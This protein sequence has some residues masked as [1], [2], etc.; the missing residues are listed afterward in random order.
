MLNQMLYRNKRE[1]GLFVLD[2]CGYSLDKA[3][4]HKDV[5]S[6]HLHLA[7]RRQ[8]IIDSER[9]TRLSSKPFSWEEGGDETELAEVLAFAQA[10]V[11]EVQAAQ[12]D[13]LAVRLLKTGYLSQLDKA[14]RS[15][16]QAIRFLAHDEPGFSADHSISELPPGDKYRQL[17]RAHL[18][19]LDSLLLL[20]FVLE[21]LCIRIA[22]N[23]GINYLPQ[24]NAQVLVTV[25]N[26]LNRWT[27]NN[28]DLEIAALKL[29][30]RIA[31]PALPL[32]NEM[33]EV[34]LNEAIPFMD[35]FIRT[36][37]E[38]REEKNKVFSPHNLIEAE[39]C[40][41][42]LAS[43]GVHFESLETIV[44][45][46]LL[47]PMQQ[48]A[49][50]VSD[51]EG[52]VIA[53]N[54]LV[55]TS[56]LID[57]SAQ[58][59][60][61]FG[62]FDR[63]ASLPGKIGDEFLP[64]WLIEANDYYQGFRQTTNYFQDQLDKATSTAFNGLGQFFSRLLSF[65]PESMRRYFRYPDN[66]TLLLKSLDEEKIMQ[67]VPSEYDF[68][69][70]ACANDPSA[71]LIALTFYEL[72][73]K[74]GIDAAMQAKLFDPFFR[75]VSNEST[76][77]MV[78]SEY[79]YWSQG[80]PYLQHK[81]LCQQITQ[82]GQHGRINS[83][84]Q[85][86]LLI[87]HPIK[88]E[89][90]IALRQ[91]QD[92][93]LTLYNQGFNIE[94]FEMLEQALGLCKKQFSNE[95][96]SLFST[97]YLEP[98]VARILNHFLKISM[99]PFLEDKIDRQ[100]M[101]HDTSILA[102]LDKLPL[103]YTKIKQG[104]G[105]NLDELN[106]LSSCAKEESFVVLDWSKHLT[107]YLS[108]PKAAPALPVLLPTPHQQLVLKLKA[109]FPSLEQCLRVILE[110]L[111]RQ[112]NSCRTLNVL[113]N[114]SSLKSLCESKLLYLEQLQ[115]AIN[116][117]NLE[118]RTRPDT[119]AATLS[120][121]IFGG[122]WDRLEHQIENATI[123]SISKQLIRFSWN[124]LLNNSF[125]IDNQFIANLIHYSFKNTPLPQL[126][127]A[128]NQ[129]NAQ[130]NHISV[131]ELM[132]L[133]ND[134]LA[135]SNL[136]PR[137]EELMDQM[138]EQLIGFNSANDNALNW[139]TQFIASQAHRL[140]GSVSRETLA[141]LLP[142]S[143]LATAAF[144]VLQSDT[145]R[146]T[147]SNL[148]F[149]LTQSY[150]DSFRFKAEEMLASIK[151]HLYPLLGIEIQK[152]IELR[153][154]NYAVNRTSDEDEDSHIFAMYYLQYR[155]ILQ[156]NPQAL[157]QAILALIFSTLSE[158][159]LQ[160]LVVVFDDLDQTMGYVPASISA[161]STE[162]ESQLD[163]LMRTLNFSDPS[164]QS[165]L[166]LI[167]L[168][169]LLVMSLNTALQLNAEQS[170]LRQEEVIRVLARLFE[171]FNQPIVPPNSY[172]LI[173]ES[174]QK[175][176]DLH[177]NRLRQQVETWRDELSNTM[178]LKSSRLLANKE[179]PQLNRSVAAVNRDL[180]KNNWPRLIF[181]I[182]IGLYES[183]S[184][185]SF[186]A[187]IVTPVVIAATGASVLQAI[188]SILGITAAVG[189]S[190]TVVGAVTL[191]L[192]FM[193][194]FGVKLGQ[195]IKRQ[196][197]NFKDAANNPSYSLGK[198]IG[199]VI[200]T[201]FKCLGWALFRSAFTD[202]LYGKLMRFFPSRAVALIQEE[203]RVYPSVEQVEEEA[204]AL[205]ELGRVLNEFN[206]NMTAD[207][208][209][210]VKIAI[211]AAIS[212]YEKA[213]PNDMRQ[214]NNELLDEI[215][216]CR[217][218]L[219]EINNMSTL[220]TNL[221]LPMQQEK[222]VDQV[223]QLEYSISQDDAKQEGFLHKA[224]IIDQ[225]LLQAYLEEQKNAEIALSQ[226]ESSQPMLIS[227]FYKALAYAGRFFTWRWFQPSVL[228]QTTSIIP[229]SSSIEHSTS[230]IMQRLSVRIGDS[231]N[232]GDSIVLTAD[233]INEAVQ[234]FI[235]LDLEEM[236]P[237]VMVLSS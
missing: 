225:R 217:H 168:N 185:I 220:I 128:Y 100:G 125:G 181:K 208:L 45:K 153:A 1:L 124:V 198:K 8:T 224:I 136:V 230:T 143:F 133:L 140:I 223:L 175:L 229:S 117:I 28:H 194:R 210:K 67:S 31:M 216:R 134:P 108:W 40:G 48:C 25:L 101:G 20:P 232:T 212:A 234:E 24:K 15:S 203:L 118:I 62:H 44:E 33:L 189:T 222:Y 50:A 75:E 51:L 3:G 174:R 127:D 164:N 16:E 54:Q 49:A 150:H 116:V 195:E 41:R 196:L 130:L 39:A 99:L 83:P 206:E 235:V 91:L 227:G 184:F 37:R 9:W 221:A 149:N 182:L 34:I 159:Q 113:L 11:A 61:L 154:L 68:S 102:V 205:T 209:D 160:H 4:Y 155:A 43:L 114:Q 94:L 204:N 58:I 14:H 109:L 35:R 52:I 201:I 163:F 119:L 190:A 167:L 180:L 202:F 38:F 63:L 218:M 27:N 93:E 22:S 137:G 79:Q 105:L 26:N 80:F 152:S 146:Q 226:N 138:V 81:D 95:F 98:A 77:V 211:H 219:V 65:V 139:A 57:G 172:D 60:R 213:L 30:L 73:E 122:A 42:L 96:P 69:S 6:F 215:T 199:K 85:Q 59:A 29:A 214:F 72:A 193:I 64:A 36:H 56:N 192:M 46:T 47:E 78:Y 179:E 158:E 17:L 187:S 236:E 111:Y 183:F 86:S 104:I 126:L 157:R 169:R 112:S 90:L 12:N 228:Q 120:D 148:I 151:D 165:S 129:F 92:I 107:K 32:D 156:M 2:L 186:W 89:L 141:N 82:V 74:A 176:L 13:S 237:A 55:G 231:L 131:P 191:G 21:K 110:Q 5:Y 170:R 207:N 166:R 84:S 103:I 233:E 97:L 66:L 200:V 23:L 161:S 132:P 147:C 71:L 19:Y 145:L 171:Q 53:S 106:C 76:Q 135:P 177:E 88:L 18:A 10:I 142:Y 121:L 144:Q 173:A 87:N 115:A 123:Y 7:F 70:Y 188:Y 178:R 162:S 197:P